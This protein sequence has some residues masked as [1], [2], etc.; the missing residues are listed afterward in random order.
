MP[1]DEDIVA[2][3]AM[4]RIFTMFWEMLRNGGYEY[5]DSNYHPNEVMLE[6]ART[7]SSECVLMDISVPTEISRWL[8]DANGRPLT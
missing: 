6:I 1:D 3:Y 7:I 5:S 4:I 2:R 8:V